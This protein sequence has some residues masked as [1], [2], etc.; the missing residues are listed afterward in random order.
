MKLI[1]VTASIL[2]LGSAQFVFFG[3]RFGGAQQPGRPQQPRAPFTA[4][5]QPTIQFG[6]T[7]QRFGSS[8]PE[9][10]QPAAAPVTAAPI[11][12]APALSFGHVKEKSPV[13]NDLT[14]EQF[15]GPLFRTGKKFHN[16]G[17]KDEKVQVEEK[18]EDVMF[19]QILTEKPVASVTEKPAAVVGLK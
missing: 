18:P 10:V 7:S 16:P 9:P 11:A 6:T 5:A 12:A 19:V 2:S 13:R 14:A 17:K 15:F 1:L 8:R 4:P 3:N